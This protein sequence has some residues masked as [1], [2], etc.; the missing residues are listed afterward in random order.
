MAAFVS[1][2]TSDVGATR[3]RRVLDG[4]ARDGHTSS[5]TPRISIPV[6]PSVARR[7]R[8]SSVSMPPFNPV[9]ARD[10]KNKWDI[11]ALRQRLLSWQ[12]EA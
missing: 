7:M 2:L 10:A 4:A 6:A 3:A 8:A 5:T 12:V 11:A 9:I 1:E